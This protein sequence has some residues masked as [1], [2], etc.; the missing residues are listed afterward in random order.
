MPGY[1]GTCPLTQR[2]LIEEFFL[3][4]RTRVL[5]L[6]AFLD[7]MERAIAR[8]AE[9]DFRYLALRRA[10]QEL[11]TD[12]PGKIDRI[13]LL[14]SDQSTELRGMRDRQSAYGAAGQDVAVGAGQ[15]AKEGA[16]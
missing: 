8:D 2:Q 16:R 14:L 3:E 5:E 7:R 10:L 11:S 1:A 12:A 6:A 4:Q 9:D 13:Q 15:E